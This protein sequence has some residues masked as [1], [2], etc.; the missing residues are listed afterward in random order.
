MLRQLSVHLVAISYS[1]LIMIL[2]NT[3]VCMLCNYRYNLI[4]LKANYI[5]LN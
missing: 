2:C 5:N 1:T 4:N 3:V